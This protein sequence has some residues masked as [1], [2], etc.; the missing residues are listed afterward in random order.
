MV[1]GMVY[2]DICRATFVNKFSKPMLGDHGEEY[3]KVTFVKSGQ[4]DCAE[5]PIDGLGNKP[6]AEITLIV[7]NGFHDEVHHANS[8]TFSTKKRAPQC[9]ELRKELEEDY[10]PLPD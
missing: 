8:L 4:H 6:T 2:C 1:K 5:I 3:C 9:E 7:N 10:I